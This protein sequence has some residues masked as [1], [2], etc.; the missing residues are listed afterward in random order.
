MKGGRISA[1][2]TGGHASD[3]LGQI[4]QNARN[5]MYAAYRAQ[6]GQ[7][8]RPHAAVAVAAAVLGAPREGVGV[9]DLGEGASIGGRVSG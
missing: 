2:K 4:K 6:R 5:T 1:G 9:R 8:G 3:G 7:V